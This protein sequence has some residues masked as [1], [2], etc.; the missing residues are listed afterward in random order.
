MALSKDEMLDLLWSKEQIRDLVLRY[1][2][3]CDR[4]DFALLESV[5]H[6]DAQ[7]EHG[8]NKSG[9]A[10]EF[11]DAIPA[12]RPGLDELQHNVTNHLISIDGDKAEG[13]VYIVAYH[14]FTGP[15]GPMLMVTGGRYLDLYERRNGEW[16]ISH[17]R[18]IDDWSV[19][20]PAPAQAANEFTDGALPRGR[21]G[22]TDPSYDFFRLLTAA[23]PASN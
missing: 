17:R 19:N 22:K 10:R 1:C 13:E 16:R 8:F 5:Y 6:P 18:C 3:A 4:A 20:L 7:D 9:L 23:S 12:M 15:E 21:A 11:L 14:R 2:R